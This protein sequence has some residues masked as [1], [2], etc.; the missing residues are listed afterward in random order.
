[1]AKGKK[2]FSVGIN[3]REAGCSV[4]CK[5]YTGPIKMV[6]K[7]LNLHIIKTHPDIKINKLNIIHTI[8]QV[9]SESNKVLN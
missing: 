3:K 9:K 7:L 4:C 1:M 8:T 5:S 6:T 2:Y